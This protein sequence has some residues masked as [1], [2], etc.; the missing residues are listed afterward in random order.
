MQIKNLTTQEFNFVIVYD[1]LDLREISRDG[2][3]R[4][5]PKH[6]PVLQ[7]I[8]NELITTIYLE[9]G[10]T[11]CFITNRR[12]RVEKKGFTGVEQTVELL[13][14]VNELVVKHHNLVAYGFNYVLHSEMDDQAPI[15]AIANTFLRDRAS[16]EDKFG[17]DL[18]NTEVTVV[19]QRKPERIQ[20]A[21]GHSDK[22]MIIRANVHFIS[23]ELP[24]K[25]KLED[26]FSSKLSTIEELL[27]GA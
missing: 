2:L 27:Y 10:P 23:S 12:V 22:T 15:E 17:G 1:E 21:F 4:A 16:L 7:E 11:A 26:A 6:Q 13:A 8:P 3:I 25:K 24:E 5:L 19:F 14:G 18:V 9:L 20:L